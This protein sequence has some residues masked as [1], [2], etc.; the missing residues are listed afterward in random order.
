MLE[1]AV[2]DSVWMQQLALEKRFILDKLNAGLPEGAGF[3]DIRLVLGDVE[4]ARAGRRTI[5]EGMETPGGP[6]PGSPG[7]A[8]LTVEEEEMF[9]GVKDPE[10]R[11]ALARLYLKGKAR[12]KAG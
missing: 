9:S 8:V 10:L 4:R 1:V 2:S 12:R 3:K 11:E 7:D 6:E 5:G